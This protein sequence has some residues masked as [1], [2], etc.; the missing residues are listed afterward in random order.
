VDVAVALCLLVLSTS[1]IEAE[2]GKT[3]GKHVG[4]ATSFEMVN[5]E[6]SMFSFIIDHLRVSLPIVVILFSLSS[7]SDC[8]VPQPE[9]YPKE[10]VRMA[11]LHIALQEGFSNDSVE[12]QID[13]KEV[14]RKTEIKTRNQIGFAD[15]FDLNLPQGS[16]RLSISVPTRQA[17]ET[18]TLLLED[19]VYLGISLTREGKITYQISGEPFRYL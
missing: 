2:H 4:G 14:F 19:P 6:F 7:F 17:S 13:G 16:V 1:C 3:N 10:E 8:E 18:I 12:I 5:R 15:S 9:A 11:L